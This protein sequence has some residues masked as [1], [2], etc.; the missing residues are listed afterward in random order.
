MPRRS[1]LANDFYTEMLAVG[2]FG[3][4]DPTTSPFQV[5]PQNLVAIHNLIPNVQ[6]GGYATVPGRIAALATNLPS[7]PT[8]IGKMQRAGQPDVYF[9]AVTSGGVGAIYYAP[10]GGTPVQ[11]A[12]PHALTPGLLTYF[13]PN[14]SWLFVS[15][16][17]DTPIKID[18]TLKATLW[19]I[20]APTPAPTLALSGPGPLL[21]VY[22]YCETFSNS[23]QESGQGAISQPITANGNSITVSLTATTTD[24]QVTTR[25]L[26]RLGGANGEFQLINS[27]PVGDLAPFLDVIA[28]TAV[29]GQS[30]TIFRDPPPA[31]TA[32]AE[33]Q[34][35]VFG[36]GTT[37]DP[38]LVGW[39][40]YNEPWGFN[41]DTNTLEAGPN[42]FNDV[43]VS[44]G[45]IGSMLVLNKTRR[46]YAVVGYSDDTFTVIELFPVGCL[47]AQ[48]AIYVDG[49]AAWPSKRGI[50]LWNGSSRLNI[51]RGA[52]Q[53]S[54][55]KAILDGY[56]LADQSVCVGFYYDTLLCWSFPTQNTTL[57][58]D[59]GSSQWFV[60]DFALGSVVYDPESSVPVVGSNLSV[61]GD[62]DQWFASTTAG[63]LGQPIVA[64]VT[65]RITDN[66]QIHADKAFVYCYV[67]AP[68][69]EGAFVNVYIYAN[70][71]P[72][73][74]R[75]ANYI[76]LGNGALRHRWELRLGFEGQEL[77]LVAQTISLEQVSIHK[78]SVWGKTV[79][80]HKPNTLDEILPYALR[81]PVVVVPLQTVPPLPESP[82]PYDGPAPGPQPP[83]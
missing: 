20:V 40:N 14:R 60:L 12:L 33:Y 80:V 29:T 81:A 48:G 6:Y 11:L 42:S 24:P 73:Q 37:A 52:F 7:T 56:S 45:S 79:R 8:G 76:D 15:N 62:V 55:V 68:V 22:Y 67:E 38:T 57:V 77:Q 17:T 27:Q 21:G 59:P 25:N 61:A 35:R 9:F 39:S 16:G 82:Y 2:P 32:I 58:F 19:G 46:T 74:I 1:Q 53:Q 51:S 70:P 43:A 66:G 69:Q 54:N 26:Y 10:I 49:I 36:F 75:E 71:G 4:V 65:S 72:G 50:Q 18:T 30:L 83:L 34:D 44:C 63:D 13:V 64:S 47:A 5:A 31:W 23:V 3:G 78:I 28:D 41:L